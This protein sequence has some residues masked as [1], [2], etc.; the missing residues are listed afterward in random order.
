MKNIIVIIIIIIII[1]ITPPAY[2]LE[3]TQS[4]T[5]SSSIKAKLDQLKKEIASK[6]AQLK[7]EINKKIKNKAYVGVLKNKSENTLTLAAS[8]GPKIVNINQDTIFESKVKLKKK[9]SKDVLTQED[10][11]ACLGDVDETGVLTAKKVILLPPPPSPKTY[12]WG[13]MISS[14][15]SLITLKDNASKQISVSPPRGA[16]FRTNDFVILTGKLNENKQSFSSNKVF[17]AKF[18]YVIPQ[19][20]NLKT[21]KEVQPQPSGAEAT[22][23]GKPSPTPTP[24]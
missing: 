6:A 2:A 22:A 10:Y 20:V 3:S 14:G 11:I 12:L 5:P 23:S 19:G 24:R 15:D 13:Q 9:F 7:Q 16:K 8:S 18:L 4:A 1:I 17:E 21:K